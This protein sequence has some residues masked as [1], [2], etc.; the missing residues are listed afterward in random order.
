MAES[1]DLVHWTKHGPVFESAYNGKY[2]D[3]GCKSGAILT[4]PEGDHLW[5]VKIDGLYWMYW[6]EGSIHSA[7][8][9]D[10]INWK[11]VEDSSGNLMNLLSPRQGKFDSS[12]AE[13]GPP[14][15]LLKQGIVVIYNG[16]NGDIKSGDPEINAGAYSGGEALFDPANP[17]HLL[18]RLDKPFIRPSEPYEATG[19]YAAG[20]V[21]VEGLVHFK[22]HWML[23]YGT[24]DSKVALATAPDRSK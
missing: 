12:L 4:R 2:K 8:S 10:L 23:Y 6:G 7:T 3:L 1:R 18:D 9:E 17:T 21:F 22:K 20:T 15:L 24:A 5:A 19:Q 11:P 14:A 13:G 16:K